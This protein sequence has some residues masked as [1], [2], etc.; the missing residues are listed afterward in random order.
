[1]FHT[2]AKKSYAVTAIATFFILMFLTLNLSYTG[3]RADILMLFFVNGAVF[4]IF[5][6]RSLSKYSY[7]LEL[8]FWIFMLYFMFFAPLVQY[9]RGSFPWGRVDAQLVWQSNLLLLLFSL[10]FKCGTRLYKNKEKKDQKEKR[11]NLLS[12]ITDPIESSTS[13]SVVLLL[14]SICIL[15]YTIRSKGLSGL[16]VTRGENTSLYS[17][18]SSSLAL[19]TSSLVS[20]FLTFATAY[21]FCIMPKEQRLKHRPLVLMQMLCLLLCC[22]PT[23]LSRNKM[24]CIY[25]GLLL[26]M[27]RPLHKGARFYWFFTFAL[28]FMFPFMELFRH[29][30]FAEVEIMEFINSFSDR[31]FESY[32]EAHYDAFSMLGYAIRY[33]QVHGFSYGR[34]LLGSLLFFVPRSIWPTKPIGSGATIMESLHREFTN[35][36]CPLVGEGY[37]NFGIAGVVLFG[38][39]VGYLVSWLD[40]RYWSSSNNNEQ[41]RAAY[42]FLLPMFFF[43]LRGDLMSS[44]AY[45]MGY[46]AVAF[47]LHLVCRYLSF[48]RLQKEQKRNAERG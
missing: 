18:E 42:V 25:M 27:F 14:I 17:G 2:Q 8:M 40:T 34:Q 16:I 20:A 11:H 19:L 32:T 43:M 29:S 36:S 3:C 1:M 12:F 21:A 45:T 22:F 39:A 4:Y 13:F 31:F 24:A 15:L 38:L 30:T 9:T 10:S 44:W 6:L 48:S 23:A 7:S 33:T 28:I 5:T 47:M 26:I 46:V 37:I 41:S 35:V